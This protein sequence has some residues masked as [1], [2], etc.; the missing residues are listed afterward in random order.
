MITL[1]LAQ[2]KELARFAEQEGQQEYTITHGEIPAFEDS[3]GENVPAYSGLIAF[4]GS[5][6]SGVLQLG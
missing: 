2:I 1:S 3:T 4:S 6:D 5:V